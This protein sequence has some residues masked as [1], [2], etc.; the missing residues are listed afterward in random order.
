VLWKLPNVRLA[1]DII[2]RIP[3]PGGGFPVTNTLLCTWISIIVLFFMF[4]AARKGKLIPSGWQNAME[5]MIEA[6]LGLVEGVVGK[7]RGRKFF[8]LVAT[9]FLFILVSNLLDVIPGVDTVGQID[10]AAIQQIDAAAH[11][12]YQPVLGFLLFGPISNAIIPWIRPATTD[13]NLNLAMALIAVVV[14][15]VFGFATLGAGEHL[16]KYFNFKALFSFNLTGFIEFFVGLLEIISE[17]ARIISL[18][19]RLFGNVFAGS[20]VLAVFA[21]ILPFLA[22]VIFIPFELF[23]AVVQAFVFALL[24]LTYLQLA[25]TSHEHT[26]SEQEAREEVAHNEERERARAAA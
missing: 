7:E 19:F 23:V 16:S 11:A 2:F 21:F 3:L 15:Q 14:A 8:P 6:L 10:G 18:T 4:F 13:L 24:S 20:V 17:L 5:W 12:N 26:E 22:D 1:P 25:T 9:F